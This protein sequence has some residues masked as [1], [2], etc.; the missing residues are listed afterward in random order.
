MTRV[1]AGC[2]LS[3]ILL[4]SSFVSVNRGLASLYAYPGKSSLALWRAGKRQP[5]QPAWEMVRSSLE[6][7]LAY[8]RRN[9]DLLHELG[10]AYDA[11]V[12]IYPVG[13]D[14]A[15]KNRASARKYYI[16]ALAR[17]PTWPHDWIALALVKYRLGQVDAEFYQA[18]HQA[19]ALGPWEPSVKYVVADIGMHHWDK[20]DPAMRTLIIGIIHDGVKDSVSAM[21][22]LNL[23]RRYD[24]LDVVCNDDNK[25]EAVENYCRKYHHPE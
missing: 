6:R 14:A 19:V 17:R 8:D 23:V 1:I 24:M 13:D 25:N 20:F 5:Q 3:V 22:M 9:P 16:E 4:F 12:D 2:L 11:E 7:A 15:G 21:S 10:A 18:L